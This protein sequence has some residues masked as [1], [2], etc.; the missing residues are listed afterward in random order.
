MRGDLGESGGDGVF[1][2]AERGED[3]SGLEEGSDE[4]G[5]EQLMAVGV[6]G[7]FPSDGGSSTGCMFA[8]TERQAATIF[9]TQSPSPT[10]DRGVVYRIDTLRVDYSCCPTCAMYISTKQYSQ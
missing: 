4:S 8:P 1:D 6:P 5:L 7:V 3:R 2:S 9:T 10:V